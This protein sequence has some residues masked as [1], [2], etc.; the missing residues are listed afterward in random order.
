MKLKGIIGKDVSLTGM[1]VTKRVTIQEFES[2]KT[3]RRKA[4][5]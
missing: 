4:T 3:L 2:E 5:P 1:D